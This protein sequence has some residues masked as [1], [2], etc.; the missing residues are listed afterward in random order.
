M[1]CLWRSPRRARLCSACQGPV[2]VVGGSRIKRRGDVADVDPRSSAG[3]CAEWC[4]SR[5]HIEEQVLMAMGGVS[6]GPKAR[7]RS[8]RESS[9]SSSQDWRDFVGPFAKI[10]SGCHRKTRGSLSCRKREAFQIARSLL[11]GKTLRRSNQRRVRRHTS[12]QALRALPCTDQQTALAQRTATRQTPDEAKAAAAAVGRHASR[13][14]RIQ[15]FRIKHALSVAGYR[16]RDISGI[17]NISRSS[18]HPCGTLQT[19]VQVD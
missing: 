9:I 3:G 13:R 6:G 14:S 5:H 19:V 4:S 8:G 12:K 17:P 16:V 7:Y 10:E 11:Q 15:M 18:N 2:A 1:Q